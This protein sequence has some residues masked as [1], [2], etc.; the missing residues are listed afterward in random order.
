V[1]DA[2]LAAPSRRADRRRPRSLRRRRHDRRP[3]G[4]IDG[5]AFEG[6]FVEGFTLAELKTL[7]ATERLPQ[8]RQ[9]NTLYDGLYEVPT[10]QQVL[11]LRDR[12][13]RELGRPVGVYPET[14]HPTYHDSLGLSLEEPLVR[15]LERNRLNRRGAPVFVQ[16]FEVAN[17]MELSGELRVPIVQL[18]GSTGQPFDFTEAGDACTYDDLQTLGGLAA[19]L[20]RRH[21]PEQGAGDPGRRRRPWRADPPGGGRPRR[22]PG[23]AL[24]HVPQ[25]EPVP[26]AR[27]ARQPRHGGGRPG[28]ARGGVAATPGCSA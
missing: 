13:S 10:F 22:R 5:I 15:A 8:V 20:C 21:R 19:G 11:D 12:L 1:S 24:V 3:D 9:E 6:F 18:F 17:L 27:A 7:R 28:A 16:S 23:G 25:R 4:T 14:K 26:A 2:T